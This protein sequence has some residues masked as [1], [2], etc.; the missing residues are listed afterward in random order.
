MTGKDEKPVDAD[1][2]D[3][4]DLSRRAGSGFARPEIVK[5]RNC[6]LVFDQFG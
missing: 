2:F 1:E 6:F 4:L 5:V 3:G